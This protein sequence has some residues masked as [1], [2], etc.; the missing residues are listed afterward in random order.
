MRISDGD[1]RCGPCVALV[2]ELDQNQ[3][4]ET[5]QSAGSAGAALR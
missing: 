4:T 1:R 2:G 3:S 5:A